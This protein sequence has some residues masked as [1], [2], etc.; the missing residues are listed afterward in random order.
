[1]QY[2]AMECNETTFLSSVLALMYVDIATYCKLLFL[3]LLHQAKV[4]DIADTLSSRLYCYLP[5]ILTAPVRTSLSQPSLWHVT[6]SPFLW[7]K[8]FSEPSITPLERCLKCSA[9][10]GSAAGLK[11]VSMRADCNWFC[12]GGA[13][14]RCNV[15]KHCSLLMMGN[16]KVLDEKKCLPTT[17]PSLSI[18]LSLTEGR[19]SLFFVCLPP[20]NNSQAGVINVVL[21]CKQKKGLKVFLQGYSPSFLAAFPP[22]HCNH[23]HP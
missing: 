16:E 18:L 10:S 13:E 15:R 22:S 12:D 5:N 20:N 14:R 9:H 11:S 19:I 8:E 2:I 3:F 21:M 1:M 6:A 4:S 23:K 7:R 17:I